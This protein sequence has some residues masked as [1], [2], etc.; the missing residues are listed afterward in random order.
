MDEPEGMASPAAIAAGADDPAHAK[1][2]PPPAR[3]SDGAHFSSLQAYRDE[4]AASV[5][6]PAGWWSRKA[7]ETLSWFRPF[8]PGAACGGGFE[9]G[10]VRGGAAAAVS[11][12]SRGV[13]PTRAAFSPPCPQVRWFSDGQLNACYNCVRAA[14]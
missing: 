6:D 12:L 7:M 5:A 13:P 8:T 10:D 11:L 14:T 1:L 4:Y 9:A 2:Y 3:V